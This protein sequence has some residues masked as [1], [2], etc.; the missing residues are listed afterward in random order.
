MATVTELVEGKSTATHTL[1]GSPVAMAAET[2]GRKPP[3]GK[4]SLE[5]EMSFSSV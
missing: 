2:A 5:S 1:K 4:R 3:A